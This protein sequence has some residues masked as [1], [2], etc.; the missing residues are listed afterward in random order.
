MTAYRLGISVGVTGNAS[1]LGSA[2]PMIS[3]F[4]QAGSDTLKVI[5]GIARA[6]PMVAGGFLAAG[7]TR[8]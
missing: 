6:A 8:D 5:Q 1:F 4:V 2:Q 7:P 3:A